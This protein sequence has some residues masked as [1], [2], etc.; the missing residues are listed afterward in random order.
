MLCRW[1]RL[2][3]PLSSRRTRDLA[4]LV[5]SWFAEDDGGPQRLDAG[6]YG[7][8]LTWWR[9][10]EQSAVRHGWIGQLDDQGV[11]FTDVEVDRERGDIAIYVR[12]PFRGRGIGR[13]LLRLAA[14]EAPSL[15]I[16]ELVGHVES[17]GPRRPSVTMRDHGA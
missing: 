11:G 5:G 7:V 14:A 9:L 8:D 12:R 1:V 6:F 13:Q 3:R 2:C 15:G 4:A 10:V 17:G 16:A